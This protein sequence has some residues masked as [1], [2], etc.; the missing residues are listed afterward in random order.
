MTPSPPRHDASNIEWAYYYL[1][2]GWT[3]LPVKRGTKFPAVKWTEYQTRQPTPR[4]IERWNW[5]GGI[6][7]VTNGLICVDCDGGGEQLLKG[8]DFPPSWTVR[9][10]SG[11][12]HR[13]YKANGQPTRNAVAILK[14]DD[15]AQVDIRADGGFIIVPP[16][17]HIKTGKPYTWILPPWLDTLPLAPAPVWIQEAVA[18]KRQTP[19]NQF[20]QVDKRIPNGQRDATLT[21]LAG[22][23]RRRGMDEKAILAALLE[24]NASKCDPPLPDHEVRKIAHSVA[25]YEPES[26]QEESDLP[27]EAPESDMPIFPNAAYQGLA[28]EV[29]H[30]YAEYLEV[31]R[32]FLYI[33]ALTFLGASLAKMVRL[34]SELREEPRLYPVKVGASSLTRKSSGQEIIERLYAPILQD[35]VTMCYG[36][37]SAEG[38]QRVMQSGLPT[39]L[40]YDEFRAF[41]D[42]AGVQQSVLLPMVA[43]LFHRTVYENSTK[44]SQIH[45]PDAHLSLIGACTTDTFTTMF[46][47]QFRNIGFLNR[48]F[49]VTGKREKLHPIPQVV[50][51]EVV[52]R[53]QER[54]LAQVEKAEK[55]RPALQFTADARLRWEEWYRAMPASPYVARLDTYGLRF[56]MLFAVTTESWEITRELVDAVIPLLDYELA[57]RREFDPVDAEGAIARMERL[58]LRH[59]RKGRLT[60]SRL[61]RLC[62]VR[63]YGLWTYDLAL[64]NLQGQDWVR[65][66]LAG[67]GRQ[68]WL[69][70]AGQ[71][72]ASE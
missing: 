10:G 31:P 49:V 37:G 28:A 7:I 48:L 2:L 66:K 39:I 68:L 59:L 16:S 60:E 43:T 36:A 26:P 27:A 6:G 4:E 63:Y 29:A 45:L 72:A 55:D 12:L 54:T 46:T 61:Q 18:E 62:N 25:R 64:K 70:E 22:T 71:E 35:R 15:G 13:Y 44:T 47:P 8:K 42:K 9:T 3:P 51:F 20:I 50:P 34:D 56:L 52:K 41:V 23:M 1:N 69:T 53:L 67:K 24:E 5:S 40:M 14:G 58:I 57:L 21:S 38:L 17:Q 30:T 11:G 33:D 19:D 32:E 65:K